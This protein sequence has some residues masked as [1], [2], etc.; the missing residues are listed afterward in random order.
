MTTDRDHMFDGDHELDEQ[1]SRIRELKRQAEDTSGGE[2][3]SVDFAAPGPSHNP[4]HNPSRNPSPVAPEQF[5]ATVHPHHAAAPWTSEFE[6]LRR[7]GVELP[8]PEQLDDAGV[9]RKV[10]EIADAMRQRNV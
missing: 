4:P 6:Q 9:A 1:E 7:Q 5:W 2:V 8:P 10:A 3:V